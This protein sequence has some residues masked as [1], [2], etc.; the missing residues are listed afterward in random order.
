MDTWGEAEINK[1]S[2][3]FIKEICSIWQCPHVI[4]LNQTDTRTEFDIMDEVDV[5]GRMPC[6]VEICG[7]IIHVD[8]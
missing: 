8:S 7:G 6:E 4:N 5:T 3:W 2:E 1:R